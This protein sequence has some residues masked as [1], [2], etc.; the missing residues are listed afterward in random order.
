MDHKNT[1]NCTF[2]QLP[3]LL[4][5]DEQFGSSYLCQ[6][7]VKREKREK[8]FSGADKMKTIG[9]IQTFDIYNWFTLKHT[10]CGAKG[11][12]RRVY[13]GWQTSKEKK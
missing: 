3:R 2:W 7:K 13:A 5:L 6:R 4:M 12:E 1:R 11:K 10:L 8:S 9:I